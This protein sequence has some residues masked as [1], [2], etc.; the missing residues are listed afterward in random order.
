ML[1]KSSW[2]LL[3]GLF[4]ISAHSLP[5]WNIDTQGS[6]MAFSEQAPQSGIINTATLAP[7]NPDASSEFAQ[8]PDG[9][10]VVSSDELVAQGSNDCGSDTKRLPRKM[11]ARNEKV[12]PIDSLPLNNGEENG[13]Q[14]L[15]TVPN[16]Q[17]GGGGQNSGG[18][19]EPKRR[20]LFP[21]KD[22]TNSYLFIPDENRPKRNA[23][24][25]PEPM[26]PVPVC[27]RPSDASALMYPDTA[28][29]TID[30]CYPC[31]FFCCLELF[32]MINPFCFQH[33]DEH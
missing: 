11:R 8:I 31:T 17:Q 15:P 21:P 5:E 27:G 18:N 19:G 13:R 24:L 1:T 28:D 22:D 32:P 25:C 2:Q 14:L 9:G 33:G 16:A 26:H 20:L 4:V 29:L 10:N 30:P 12:C 23:N 3:L 7:A 6:D